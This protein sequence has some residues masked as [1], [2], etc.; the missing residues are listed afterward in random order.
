MAKL[1]AEQAKTLAELKALEE[2]PD[3]DFDLVVR[4]KEGRETRLTGKHAQKWLRNLG[5]DDDDETGE[6]AGDAA[7]DEGGPDK[8]ED[9]APPVS[10]APKWFR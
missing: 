5:L 10:K 2:A 3:D 7:G 4:D 9:D 8:P 6:P 1:T